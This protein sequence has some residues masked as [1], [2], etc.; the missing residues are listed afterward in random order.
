MLLQS[1]PTDVEKAGVTALFDELLRGRDVSAAALSRL[2]CLLFERDAKVYVRSGRRKALLGRL[3]EPMTEDADVTDHVR[4]SR[5]DQSPD[6][7]W[8]TAEEATT[9]LT[10]LATDPKQQRSV[11]A[12]VV[13]RLVEY[14]IHRDFTFA[15]LAAVVR[16]TT[17]GYGRR[18]PKGWPVSQHSACR[19]PTCHRTRCLN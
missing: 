12:V 3:T 1:T 5:Y 14:G 4:G 8:L 11:R 13:K 9:T 19:R 10:K 16:A 18:R 7:T 15:V 6:G 2:D 17:T